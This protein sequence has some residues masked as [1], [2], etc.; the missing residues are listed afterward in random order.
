MAAPGRIVPGTKTRATTIVNGPNPL[1]VAT[2]AA[3]D[4]R[5]GLAMAGMLG[6]RIVGM[7]GSPSVSWRG[8]LPSPQTFKGWVGPNLAGLL[9]G[10]PMALPLTATGTASA[11]PFKPAGA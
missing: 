6:H 5:A 2:M 4:T 11:G 7:K 1:G 8:L 10:A 3:L 9:P